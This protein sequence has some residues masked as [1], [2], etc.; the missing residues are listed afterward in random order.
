MPNAMIDLQMPKKRQSSINVTH[1]AKLAGVSMATAARAF[2]DSGKLKPVTL[3]K[4][5]DAAERLN[6]KPNLLARGLR[7]GATHTVG[8]IWGQRGEPTVGKLMDEIGKRFSE[9]GYMCPVADKINSESELESLIDYANRRF[10][11]VVLQQWNANLSP[12]ISDLL[13]KFKSAVVVCP[14]PINTSFDQLVVDRFRA[15]SDAGKHFIRTGRQKVA[16]ATISLS[17]NRHKFDIFRETLLD[18][19]MV[20]TNKSIITV[21]ESSSFSTK[22][23]LAAFRDNLERRF[24]D[25]FPFDAVMCQ[26]DEVAIVLMNWL[27]GKGYKIPDD[28][29]VIGFDD[30]DL[31]PYLNPP[32]ASGNRCNSLVAD[33][34]AAMVINR[35]DNRDLPTQRRIVEMKFKWRESAG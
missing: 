19:S 5:I 25:N 4:V 27:I 6:Y 8:V 22:E 15:F 2:S 28:V 18:S 14:E 12:A 20:F 24:A 9:K 11:G 31:C 7:G 1:V 32:L 13:M 35:L 3:Q 17:A 10:D 26:N 29:A 34:I 33:M 16:F 21:D 30:I 23:H